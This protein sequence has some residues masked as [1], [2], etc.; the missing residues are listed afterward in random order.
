ML[1][2]QSDST[3]ACPLPV[4]LVGCGRL[5]EFGYIPAL[6]RVP[7]VS[8]VG[9]T[10]VDPVRCIRIA[11]EVPAYKTLHHLIDGGRTQAII[12]ATPS[13]YHLAD[14]TV[15]AQAKL[16]ALVE[17]PPGINLKEAEGFLELVPRPWLGFNRRFDPDFVQLKNRLSDQDPFKIRLEL[18]YRRKTWNPIDMQDDALLDLGP[19]LIDAVRWLT[20]NDVTSVQTR[21][22]TQQYVEFDLDFERGQGTIICCCNSP[23]RESVRVSSMDDRV[24]QT[25]RRGGILAGIVGKLF[26]PRETPLLYSLMKQLESYRCAV[27]GLPSAQPLGSVVDGVKVMAVIEAVRDSARAGGS[28]LAV[29]YTKVD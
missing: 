8:L 26:A 6:R 13:R 2:A 27:Q 29:R 9:V 14:A 28:K 5:A 7:G 19:H 18:C 10:D 15:A 23:Y 21:T 22:L 24:L 20:L 4:G 11:P 3:L 12:I 17:K 25:F 1:N 16:P